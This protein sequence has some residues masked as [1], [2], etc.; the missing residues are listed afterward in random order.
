[1]CTDAGLRSS[2]RANPR[3]RKMLSHS[4][5]SSLRTRPDAAPHFL[6][7]SP[8][9]SRIYVRYSR[10]QLLQFSEPSN[11]LIIDINMLPITVLL[12]LLPFA[13]AAPKPQPPAHLNP[14][15][16]PPPK[17]FK[18]APH[19]PAAPTGTGSGTG[20]AASPNLTTSPGAGRLRL[21][22]QRT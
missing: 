14:R 2:I 22:E 7:L 5:P 1:M 18:I 16:T 13:F 15:F 11:F 20:N 21:S 17:P 19:Y 9:K 8:L 4:S 10:T 6:S 3:P 12:S